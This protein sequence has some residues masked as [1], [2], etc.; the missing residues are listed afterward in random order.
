MAE[1]KREDVRLAQTSGKSIA[2][3]ARELDISDTS[4]QQW[5]KE[6]AAHGSESFPGSGHQTAL[7]EE[8]RRLKRELERVRQERDML[9]NHIYLLAR[10]AVRFPC[11]EQHREEYPIKV[12]CQT[13][14]VGVE[15]IVCLEKP[16]NKR[17]P[18]G[19]LLAG[20]SPSS[21]LSEESASLW[22][23]S[24]ACRIA[25]SGDRVLAQTHSATDAGAGTGGAKTTS[26]NRDHTE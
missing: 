2:Q 7:E 3:V 11:I 14:E 5:R 22:Q 20:R 24:S 6:M 18:Q 12:L 16:C 19:R 23:S 1:F 13:L 26:S 10:Q 15:W 25:S 9:K 21:G 8:K 17:A 4:I